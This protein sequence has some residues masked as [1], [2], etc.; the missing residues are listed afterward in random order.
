[1]KISLYLSL[2]LYLS[3]ILS[4]RVSIPRISNECAH[5]CIPQPTTLCTCTS[6][7]PSTCDRRRRLGHLV[8]TA[9]PSQTHHNPSRPVPCVCVCVSVWSV[10]LNRRVHIPFQSH[11]DGC[12]QSRHRTHPMPHRCCHHDVR[13]VWPDVCRSGYCGNRIIAPSGNRAAIVSKIVQ[14][15]SSPI[16]G[17]NARTFCVAVPHSTQLSPW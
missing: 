1:M 12:T 4:H 15:N 2:S 5:Q 7:D 9:P 13:D 16:F 8:C 10:I 6:C 11:R 14:A 17:T 3:A